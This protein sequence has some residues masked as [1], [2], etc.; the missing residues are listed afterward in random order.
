MRAEPDKSSKVLANW[1]TN[2]PV[3][4][5]QRSGAWCQIRNPEHL[6][7]WVACEFLGQEALTLK[8]LLQ[9]DPITGSYL[10]SVEARS[11][12]VAPSIYRFAQVG[13]SLNYSALSA[14]QQERERNTQRPIR[15]PIPEFEAMKQRLATGVLPRIEQEVARLNLLTW[16][17]FDDIDVTKIGADRIE[18]LKSMTPLQHLPPAK[19]SLFR[20][21]A[22]VVMHN[23][24]S[25]DAAASM[26]GK[27]SKVSFH[28]K[29]QWVQGR[30][31]EGVSSFWDVREVRI[32]YADPVVLHAV[33][34]HALIGA[35]KIETASVI[36]PSSDEGCS[37]G[38]GGLPEGYPLPGFARIKDQDRLL[39]FF[40]PQAL[41]R[42]KVD[43]TSVKRQSVFRID[44]NSTHQDPKLQRFVVHSVDLNQDGI[45]DMAVIE[46]QA[47][48]FVSEQLQSNR[49]EFLNI[50]GQWWYTGFVFYAECS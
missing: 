31:S 4:L 26:L 36:A 50:A 6:I 41:P 3:L 15:F 16:T 43:I 14:E 2:L 39:G 34:R 22:D 40:L 12:W 1:V 18:H 11:F 20:Q 21:H 25:I 17:S 7:G 10:P 28:G 49:Y 42:A 33:S 44:A 48:A 35:R 8:A 30:H 38:Y 9:T 47:P 46:W 23:E 29:A 5:L 37:E 24:P 13:R 27:P 19:R 45:A 32:H